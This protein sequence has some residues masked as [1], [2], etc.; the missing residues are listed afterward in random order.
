MQE[1][2]NKSRMREGLDIYR[3][4]MC[5]QL[6]KIMQRRGGKDWPQQ[7]V[8]N[9]L[10]GDRQTELLENLPPNESMG[11]MLDSLEVRDFPRVIAHN[12]DILPA[13][14][15]GARRSN[16]RTLTISAAVS[17]MHEIHTWR[18]I[19]EHSEAR[20]DQTDRDAVRLLN[21]CERLLELIDTK[22]AERIRE[23]YGQLK[24]PTSVRQPQPGQAD[25]ALIE[26]RQKIEELHVQREE[27]AAELADVRQER[28]NALQERDKALEGERLAFAAWEDTEERNAALQRRL[29]E[30]LANLTE[31]GS[32]VST[33][34][35]VP[36]ERSQSSERQ[37]AD[38]SQPSLE[39]YKDQFG[40]ARSGNG[41]T[42]TTLCQGWRVTRWVGQTYR[43]GRACVFAPSQG[44]GRSLM[45]AVEAP[46]FEETCNGFD[47]AF[48]LL[49]KA[50]CNGD[51]ENLA[52]RAIN[53]YESG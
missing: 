1:K 25:T 49:W 29:K 26:M 13:S 16:K 41:W 37:V 7:R 14:L 23:L 30:V 2:K 52:A 12:R 17:W 35:T 9:A 21:T 47:E 46:L 28:N 40:V 48:E 44:S 27:H 5:E 53:H 33:E 20:I 19:L 4:S 31:D 6:G 15:V 24:H 38:L 18:N 45:R 10:N 8:L 43:G 34:A 39:A 3:D 32:R 51:I 11:R 42:Y 50:E 36:A 22:S